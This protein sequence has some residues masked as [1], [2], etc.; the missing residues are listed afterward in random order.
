MKTQLALLTAVC[1]VMFCLS[2]GPDAFTLVRQQEAAKLD[3]LL[4]DRPGQAKA[5]DEHRRT[6]LHL[7]VSQNDPRA[8]RILLEHGA[9]MHARDELRATPVELA[10]TSGEADLVK[11]FLDHGLGVNTVLREN[12]R[13]LDI[14]TSAAENG[15]VVRLLRRRGAKTNHEIH[16]D[17]YGTGE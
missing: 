14:A 6:P 5:R 16:N 8:V 10:L 11:P 15:G 17:I 9:N 1:A 3:R 4:F 7:A 13:P 2:C 12:M